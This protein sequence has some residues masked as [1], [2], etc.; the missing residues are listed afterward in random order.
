ME[1]QKSKECSHKNILS[2]PGSFMRPDQRIDF[3]SLFKS[4][5]KH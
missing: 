4:I 5:N 2:S 3:T 1:A